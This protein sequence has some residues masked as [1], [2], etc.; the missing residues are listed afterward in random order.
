MIFNGEVYN[1]KDIRLDLEALGHTFAGCGDSE[2][3]LAAFS[4]WGLAAVER[5]IGMFA[6]A[7]WAMKESR[8]YLIRD[9]LGIKPLYYGLQ[10][11]SLIFG[12]ELKALRAFKHWT[13]Q[14][15]T[16]SVADY[17]Q[18]GYIA[19]P[20]SIYA[21]V[22]KLPP[23]HWLEVPE[24]GPP[25]LVKYWSI[26]DAAQSKQ[27]R[28][29]PEL[30]EELE[31][32]MID[33]FKLRMIADVP[34]GVFLSGG[35]DS[36]LVAAILQKHS[37]QQISTFTIGFE[38][39][40][41]NEAPYA[42]A[43]AKAL[44]TTHRTM[45]VDGG[46]AKK[47]LPGWGD[48]YD[49]P[50]GDSSGI[51]TLLV[52]RMA[53]K[54]VK[55]VL[56]ADGGDELFCGYNVYA[57]TLMKA[58]RMASVPAAVKK[59]GVGALDR[60]NIDSIDSW[61]AKGAD[62]YG[63]QQGLHKR[64]TSRLVRSRSQLGASS[65]GELYEHGFLSS[66]WN[67]DEIEG[68]LGRPVRATRVLCDSYPGSDAEQ[69]CLWD[70]HHY[71]PGDILTKVDRATMAVSIEGREPLL[72]H[73]LA[74]FAF[75]LPYELRNGQLGAKHLL[76]K[77]LYKYVPK[78]L[79]D[80]PKRGFAVP[81]KEWLSGDLKHLVDDYLDPVRLRD[82]GLF[83]VSAV[84]NVVA[85]FRAGDNQAVNKLWL[86]LAFQMWFARWMS[87]VEAPEAKVSPPVELAGA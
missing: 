30:E 51:P 15:D 72:D 69:M 18:F 71:L 29:E 31:A 77:V 10:G 27:T 63:I 4:Q 35:I 74:E 33:A 64:V 60:L 41:F 37:G 2:V 59:A 55:V 9:R 32:L 26:L 53:A 16:D 40:E 47:V 14:V 50:F 62:A 39:P 42:E 54:D 85:R 46:A 49:E 5:F 45:I 24:S 13:P 1:F 11:D 23:G 8:L 36:S 81:L 80:R 17:L 52:S 19:D 6:I 84:Q 38:Q 57:S 61:L 28:S 83:Q 21:G 7:L 44:G 34:V 78:E 65:F 87:D 12:S 67:R 76:K 22:K 48:L 20:R 86:L 3:I 66:F 70:L 58:R 56:S 73:R 75:S 79:F 82:Q 25:V 43:V 68:L